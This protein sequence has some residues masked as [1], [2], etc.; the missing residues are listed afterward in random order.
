MGSSVSK[1]C[2][3]W[4]YQHHMTSSPLVL[5]AWLEEFVLSCPIC[6]QHKT[7][8]VKPAGL[9]EPLPTP[10]RPWSHLALDFIINLPL[11]PEN[12]VILTVVE[13]FSKMCWMIPLPNLP[14]ARRYHPGLDLLVPENIMSDRWL[15]FTARVFHVFC[16]RLIISEFVL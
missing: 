11:S 10:G 9:L 12:S 1:L 5:V 16:A 3:L 2:G 7:D 14:M 6:V 15:Q 8:T 4:Q 13:F